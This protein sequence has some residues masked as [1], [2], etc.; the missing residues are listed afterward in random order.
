MNDERPSYN[1]NIKTHPKFIEMKETFE[2]L[3][4]NKGY[5]SETQFDKDVWFLKNDLQFQ[6]MLRPSSTSPSTP[7]PE[8]NKMHSLLREMSISSDMRK[9]N[10]NTGQFI[11]RICEILFNSHLMVMRSRELIKE[12]NAHENV[13]VLE[14]KHKM[15]NEKYKEQSESISK[16]GVSIGRLD[17]FPEG[18]FSFN[19]HFVEKNPRD[20]SMSI[21]RNIKLKDNKSLNIKQTGDIIVLNKN[22]CENS[23]EAVTLTALEASDSD[24]RAS[25]EYSG[26]TLSTFN[27]EIYKNEELFAVSK[28]ECFLDMFLNLIDK[29]RDIDKETITTTWKVNT[30]T[31]LNMQHINNLLTEYEMVLEFKFNLDP[32]TRASIINRILLI[33]RDAITTETQN[34]INGN[35]ILDV[36]FKSIAEQVQYILKKKDDDSSANNCNCNSCVVY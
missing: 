32:I 22:D 1:T 4:R 23:F 33:L 18:N 13:N 35:E 9:M 8:Y 3:F 11:N 36:Y 19:F 10:I 14:V 17:L 25:F 5:F 2:K 28:P 16:L 30:K 31:N 24:K 26:T 20:I 6:N 12:Y 21:S 29:L 27:I 15:L 34:L 7:M